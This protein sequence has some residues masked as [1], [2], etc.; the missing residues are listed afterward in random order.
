MQSQFYAPIDSQSTEVNSFQ[1]TALERLGLVVSLA[2]RADLRTLRQARVEQ[3]RI[4]Q[5]LL[6]GQVGETYK[7]PAYRT[8][9]PGEA[10]GWQAL[11]LLDAPAVGGV[12]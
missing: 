8:G 5:T 2:I 3:G 9:T 12:Q 10:A 1:P 6:A 7:R 11:S 4:I